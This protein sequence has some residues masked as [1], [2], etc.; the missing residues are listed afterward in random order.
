VA[1]VSNA[2]TRGPWRLSVLTPG[3]WLCDDSLD[4]HVG[5][6]ERAAV[7][8]TDDA[9]RFILKLPADAA[10]PAQVWINRAAE[11]VLDQSAVHRKVRVIPDSTAS[12]LRLPLVADGWRFP[13]GSYVLRVGLVAVDI[14]SPGGMGTTCMLDTVAAVRAALRL[15]RYHVRVAGYIACHGSLPRLNR[16]LLLLALGSDLRAVR[17]AAILRLNDLSG[18]TRAATT[19]DPAGSASPCPHVRS[20]GMTPTDAEP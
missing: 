8:A 16:D 17:E 5:M 6:L 11:T 2:G 19:N 7:Q 18:P 13:D 3:V 4:S 15:P 10:R 20:D 12:W 14:V 9:G 1:I